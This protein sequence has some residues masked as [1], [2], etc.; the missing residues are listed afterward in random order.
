[1]VLYGIPRRKGKYDDLN[2][3]DWPSF[4]PNNKTTWMLLTMIYIV[5]MPFLW[6][7]AKLVDYWTYCKDCAYMTIK[8]RNYRLYKNRKQ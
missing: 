8:R 3:T 4:E 7:V 2:D 1:M 6:I 5:I